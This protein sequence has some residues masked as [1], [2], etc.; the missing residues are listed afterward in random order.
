MDLEH[1]TFFVLAA[2]IVG[3][4][5]GA[6][7]IEKGVSILQDRKFNR[8]YVLGYFLLLFVFEGILSQAAR[9]F[10]SSNLTIKNQI[11]TLSALF[12]K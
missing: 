9:E 8:R 10:A 1:N 11:T 12:F 6:L 2:S 4:I 5:I 3:D 7:F